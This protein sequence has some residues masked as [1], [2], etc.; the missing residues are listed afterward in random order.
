VRLLK[1]LRGIIE[2]RSARY[3]AVDAGSIVDYRRIA[4]APNEKRI[5]LIV[6]NFPGFRS[7]FETGSGRA[8]WYAVFQQLLLEGR[9]LGVHVAITADRPGSVPSAISATIQRRVVHRLADEGGYILVDEPSD[10]LSAASP[11]GRALLDGLETQ[12]AVLGGNASVAEQA[13][14]LIGLGEAMSRAGRLPAPPV[15]AL[16]PEI[17]VE[18]LPASVD[19]LPVLGVSDDSLAPVGFEPTG[20]FMLGGPPGSGRTNAL[21]ALVRAID[22][23]VPDMTR[24]YIGNARSSV[25]S[26]D[27]WAAT[28][29]TLEET[30]DLALEL[31]KIVADPGTR[32]KIV[33]VIE[34]IADF[35]SSSADASLVELIKA[36]KRSDHF[37][38]GES[39][40]SQ[41]NSSWPLLGE[42]KSGRT[43]FLIQPDGIEG[44]MLL[45]T[46]LPRVSRA[47]FPPGR[48]FF[49]ARGKSV[50]V[51]LPV[52]PR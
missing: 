11:P 15:G 37:L 51:Q 7:E 45:K 8:P 49:I 12:I 41:W 17:H 39:E 5:L 31:A 48:G 43:G 30:K 16:S 9:G 28:A 26:A 14:A 21:F 36:V 33:I 52:M 25:G 38:L 4:A 6:D 19:G 40:T 3:T 32:G 1:M 50:R 23:A 13:K 24:Y 35:L 42:I 47:E 34:Q 27:G 29:R 44:E 18:S 46:P 10:V 20:T 2:D 22:L